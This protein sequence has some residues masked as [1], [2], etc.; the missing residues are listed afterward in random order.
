MTVKEKV[1]LTVLTAA[2]IVMVGCNVLLVECRKAAEVKQV[3]EN[4]RIKKE[5]LEAIRLLEA[6]E[7]AEF[8]C[9]YQPVEDEFMEQANLLS[10]KMKE[11]FISVDN[12]SEIAGER[13]DAAEDFRKK[14][15]QIGDV[16]G[17]LEA[18]Y[19]YVLEFAEN[20]IETADLV[21]SY[22]KSGSY[23]TYSKDE[24]EELNKDNNLLFLRALEELERIYKEYDLG[25][26]LQELP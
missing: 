16:P 13:L 6:E 3:E 5:M 2:M 18:F 15:I 26:L 9:R 1:I 12:L 21:L 8:G 20:D 7:I 19:G 25:F 24:L 11:K 23:S 4:V 10:E 14:L 22:Y 17:P